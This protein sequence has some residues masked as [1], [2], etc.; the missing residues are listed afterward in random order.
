MTETAVALTPLD[1]AAARGVRAGLV[2]LGSEFC[3]NLLPKPAQF[4]KAAAP[5]G[6]RVVLVTPFLT[7][8]SLKAVE[9]LI[10]SR[11]AGSGRLELVANDLG[12]VRLAAKKYRGR[13][14]LS[15]G[16]VLAGLLRNSPDDFIERFIAEHGVE[17]VEADRPDIAARW[18]RFGL[19][20]SF[21]APYAAAGLTR[22]C[23][24][25]R[26]WT[27]GRCRF[28]CRRG[29]R[30]LKSRLLPEPL[31]LSTAGYFTAGEK[32]GGRNIDRLVYDPAGKL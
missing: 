3:E 31:Y 28:S 23:P 21:H 26:R 29:P 12:L 24:W 14:A 32:P 17:R 30:A 25:E 1:L 22:F 2:Y 4:R 13:V 16:R 6:R 7:E 10:Q 8:P 20:V 5:P 27:G 9:R 19:P 15:L 18:A 11:P